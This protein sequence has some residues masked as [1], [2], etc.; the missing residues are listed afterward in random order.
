MLIS[1]EVFAGE[2]EHAGTILHWF[3][4]ECVGRAE[5]VFSSK[6]EYDVKFT[7][8]GIEVD[9]INVLEFYHSQNDKMIKEE[10]VKLIQERFA[11]I[12]EKLDNIETEFIFKMEEELGLEHDY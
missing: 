8:D 9:F 6:D 11:G 3:L 4:I 7:I 5:H 1:R 10:A 12:T 2:K